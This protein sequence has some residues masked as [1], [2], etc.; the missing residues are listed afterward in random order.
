MTQKQ[1]SLQMANKEYSTLH[2]NKI[3]NEHKITYHKKATG[4][5]IVLLFLFLL[6]GMCVIQ[7]RTQ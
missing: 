6:S 3:D 5:K 1:Q 7:T 2:S 4:K